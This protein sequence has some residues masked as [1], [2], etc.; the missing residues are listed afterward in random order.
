MKCVGDEERQNLATLNSS[1][2]SWHH[3]PP[4]PKHYYYSLVAYYSMLGIQKE[5]TTI[6]SYYTMSI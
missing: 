6:I 2:V 1:A 3:H 5:M 4:N